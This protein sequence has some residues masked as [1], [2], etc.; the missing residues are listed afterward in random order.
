LLVSVVGSDELVPDDGEDFHSPLVMIDANQQIHIEWPE[1][2]KSR[3]IQMSTELFEE[4][5]GMMN[6]LRRLCDL[7]LN[8]IALEHSQHADGSPGRVPVE[9]RNEITRLKEILRIP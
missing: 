5:V 7:L 8:V 9:M 2:G 3:N 6:A 4:W 1:S